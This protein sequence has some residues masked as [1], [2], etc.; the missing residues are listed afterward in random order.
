METVKATIR[1]ISENCFIEGMFL[2]KDKN[3]GLT[4]S[5]KQYI[6]LNLTDRTGEVKAR[7][8]D[9]AEKLGGRFSQGDIVS[10][11]AFSVLY[12]GMLQL[13]IN[14]IAR[15][16]VDET[17]IKDFLPA[18]EIDPAALFNEILKI[19]RN[20]GN[21]H[22]RQLLELIFSLPEVTEAF[23]AA[24][25]A[26]S[27]H[28]DHIGGLIEHTASVTRL[29]LA[30][31]PLYPYLDVDLLLTGALLHD[32]GKIQEL[33]YE[34]GFAYTDRGRLIGHITL[35]DEFIAGCM[36]KIPDFPEDLE[37][38]VRHLIL[39]HHGQYEFGSPK[40]PK[41]PEA[42]LLSYLDDLDSKM[43][44][45]ADQIKKER[46]PESKWTSYNKLFDRYLYTN[47]YKVGDTDGE[48]AK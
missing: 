41:T 37:L 6:A 14:D 12:Q 26:K 27:I 25:A 3:N 23:I 5:G 30:I 48:K 43:F 33:S 29:A 21:P 47:T 45:F 13:N 38:M 31:A 7:I 20:I 32:I 15:A 4:K 40:R 1:G 42:L 24:P 46:K 19:C 2:V 35:G 28:H 34:K 18:A 36:K 22:L 8:W 44:G 17:Q 10:L 16:E 39:S 11:K 9:N